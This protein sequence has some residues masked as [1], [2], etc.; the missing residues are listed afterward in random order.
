MT[1]DDI[2]DS[3]DGHLVSTP[4][5]YLEADSMAVG[6]TPFSA[7]DS[8][9]G[10]LYQIRLAL[11]WSL[12]RLPFS[13]DFLVSVET[14]DHVTFETSGG[15]PQELVQTKHHRSREASLT[16]ASPDLWKTLR[17]WFEGTDAGQIPS[18][19]ALHLLTTATASECSVA[20][21]LRKSERDVN[22][23]LAALET[24]ARSSCNEDNKIAYDVFLKASPARRR[25]IIESVIVIDAAQTIGEIDNQLRA[26]VFSA[27]DRKNL[28]SF[29]QRLEGWWIRR[30]L[31]QLNNHGDRILA[32]EIESQMG[33][34]REGFKQDSLPID[35]DLF[36]SS[37]D[38]A[39]LVAHANLTLVRQMEI[40]K[41]G[42]KR[43]ASAVRDYYRAFEQRSR[44]LRE[45]LVHVGELDQY[46]RRLVEEWELVFEG[47]QDEI[48]SEATDEAKEK[49]A[50]EVL[51]WAEHQC[52]VTIRPR[53]TEPFVVRGS[54]HM[55][56]N[57]QRI[58]WHP[59]FRG[60]LAKLLASGEKFI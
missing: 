51:R 43:I 19:T 14:L 15:T 13:T 2:E 44:W 46:E 41:A 47:M 35:E 39:V 26:A 20:S 50:R 11:L 37:S 40:I 52:T 30:V 32:E 49:A 16:D 23:A 42:G 38:D 24:T 48:G 12:Q 31:H 25:S 27:V 57:E 18:G 36:V 8:L 9:S 4:L 53:V 17:I 55:L 56:S 21:R 45:D 22:A 10:Y 54:L 28:D 60:R 59:E 5:F 33:D 7:A 29:L 3:S 58:G 6:T 1:E 34:L